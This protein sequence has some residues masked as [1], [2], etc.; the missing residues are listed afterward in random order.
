VYLP[1]G[2]FH[3]VSII[4]MVNMGLFFLAGVTA[5]LR[6]WASSLDVRGSP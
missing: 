3:D 1:N 2:V 5:G 4:P 6:P